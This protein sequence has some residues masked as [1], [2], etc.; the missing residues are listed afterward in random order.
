MVKE[1]V[2]A[3]LKFEVKLWAYSSMTMNILFDLL[4]NKKPKL[5][6]VISCLLRQL[7]SQSRMNG[8]G[9]VKHEWNKEQQPHTDF[10]DL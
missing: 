5:S 10:N 6:T 4:K 7:H 8:R 9:P 2:P 1:I 3:V